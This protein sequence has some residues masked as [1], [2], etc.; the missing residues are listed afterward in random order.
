MHL[1]LQARTLSVARLMLQALDTNVSSR[2]LL[3]T[4]EHGIVAHRTRAGDCLRK[5]AARSRSAQLMHVPALSLKAK[6]MPWR[7]WHPAVQQHFA[8]LAPACSSHSTILQV[9]SSAC[10]ICS[11]R[12][13]PARELH[14]VMCLCSDVSRVSLDQHCSHLHKAWV[15]FR[16]TGW[17]VTT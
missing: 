10:S 3:A 16:T 8:S 9:Y 15:R 5:H 2:D 11:R 4:H 17:V 6:V 7:A 14:A 12:G 13:T 1:V